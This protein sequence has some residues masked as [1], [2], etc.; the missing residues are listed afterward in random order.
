[1]Q[2]LPLLAV[3]TLHAVCSG[4]AIAC[5]RPDPTLVYC[6][7]PEAPRITELKSGR[8]VLELTV[9]P[10]GS[11]AKARVI[12][13]SGHAAWREAVLEASSRWRYEPSAAGSVKV[14]EFDLVIGG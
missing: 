9:G 11:V 4:Q 1:M 8:V 7:P 14:E 5:S 3:T 13:S 2:R 10:H 6:P 12:S